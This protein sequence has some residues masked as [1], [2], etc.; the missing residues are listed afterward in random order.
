MGLRP[1]D[2]VRV[3]IW[4]EPDLSGQF[5]VNLNGV[6]VF[7]LLGER[8]VT[9]TS[10]DSLERQLVKEYGAYLEN[11]SVNVTVLRRIAILG[12]VR[13]PGLY[14]V[15]ATVSLTDVLALAGGVSPSGN[16]DD[17]RLI[18]DGRVIRRS[19]D[20]TTV[21]ASTPIQSGDHIE[22][23]L[24]SWLSRNSWLVTTTMA[25]ATSVLIAVTIR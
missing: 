11:P 23:G 18:R 4:R 10:A 12:E 2:A 3:E 5:A 8:K 9:G 25:A 19:L 15:D 22:V 6:V 16:K 20:G 21:I 17:I 24:R 7:P 14:P 13:K 1:G